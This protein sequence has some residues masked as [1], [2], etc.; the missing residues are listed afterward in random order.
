MR[1]NF[2][3]QVQPIVLTEPQIQ[4]NQAGKGFRKMAAQLGSV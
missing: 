3:Q 2:S 4:N 1:T